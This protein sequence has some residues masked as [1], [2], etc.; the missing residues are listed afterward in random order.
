MQPRLLA[1]ICVPLIKLF[2]GISCLSGLI[3]TIALVNLATG[4]QMMQDQLQ[5]WQ[6]TCGIV[7]GGIQIATY[8]CICFI[9]YYLYKDLLECDSV[10]NVEEQ[11]PFIY[12]NSNSST[13][14]VTKTK[15]KQ[16]Q[17]PGKGYR[18][19]D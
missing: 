14:T 4:H 8:A 11:T 3:G 16:Q 7:V 1:C 10:V 9:G 13:T 2:I 15:Q 12:N 18:L 5:N 19:D 17:F 6:V